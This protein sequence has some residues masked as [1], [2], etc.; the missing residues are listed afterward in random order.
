VGTANWLTLRQAQALLNAPDIT[1]TKG[2]PDRA[3]IAVLLG[4]A[5]RRCE[6]AALTDGRCSGGLLRRRRLPHGG[7]M[8]R[9]CRYGACDTIRMSAIRKLTVAATDNGLSAPELAAGIARGKRAKSI[10]VGSGTW[11]T[12]R[13]ARRS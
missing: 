13:Q 10:G 1:T 2:L 9:S 6:G 3:I 7:R 12:R 11:L 8:G 5:L 4:C